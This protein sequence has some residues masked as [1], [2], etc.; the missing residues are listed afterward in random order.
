MESEVQNAMAD[1]AYVRHATLCPQ[2]GG[3]VSNEVA[4][5]WGYCLGPDGPPR[6]YYSLGN[7][8]CWRQ[9]RDRS[10]PPWTYFKH[11]GKHAGGNI[12]DPECRDL[13]TRGTHFGFLY[14]WRNEPDR[15]RCPHCHV[16]LDGIAIEIRDGIL[17]RVWIYSH[18]EFTGQADYF[19]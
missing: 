10:V 13:I 2:C 3:L 17:T 19:I 12:G 14:R 18:G 5:Q 6:R 11:D 1:F 4:F 8:I 15:R 7:P 9:C 16:V